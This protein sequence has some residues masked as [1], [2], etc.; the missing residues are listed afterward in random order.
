MPCFRVVARLIIVHLLLSTIDKVHDRH[1]ISDGISN[2]SDAVVFLYFSVQAIFHFCHLFRGAIGQNDYELI[3][4]DPADLRR[5]IE[6]LPQNIGE[7]AD[8]SIAGS[9]S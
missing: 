1:M 6:Y 3:A 5:F 4:A 9:M 8:I 2:G 7:F